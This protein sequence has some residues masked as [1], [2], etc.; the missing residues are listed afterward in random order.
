M[1]IKA[2]DKNM[3]CRGF[4]FE[5]G[6]EYKIEHEGR[7][8]ELCSDTVFHYCDTLRQVCFFYSIA[9]S[10]RYFEIEVMGDVVTDG[11]KCGSDHIKIVRELSKE[12]IDC[13]T[14]LDS[15]NMGLW[16]NGTYN[17]GSCNDGNN[18]IGHKNQGSFNIGSA[19]FHSSNIGH[20]NYGNYNSGDGN[21][22]HSNTGSA[23]IGSGNSG[24]FNKCNY[25]NG[26]FCNT[27]DDN[28]RIFNKPSGLSFYEFYHSKYMEILV[29]SPYCCKTEWINYAPEE[30]LGHP[31]KERT[32]G[33]LKINSLEEMHQKWRE[34]WHS[35][36]LQKQKVIQDIPNFDPEIFKD[37]TG[38]D[39]KE[40]Q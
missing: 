2:M 28:I 12:E 20:H 6:K 4:Q 3:Q 34:W 8:L 11:Y 25:S 15:P 10:S 14:G 9:C 5:I 36:T 31:D 37:I 24:W 30:M 26:V 40:E 33:Y 38:I 22:G 39:V 17:I 7:P 23:N 35:L 16:N 21:V 27:D 1:K 32:G 18:N 13:L 29:T 19:N